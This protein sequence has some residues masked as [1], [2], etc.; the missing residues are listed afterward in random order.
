MVASFTNYFV[1]GLLQW[2]KFYKFSED[3]LYGPPVVAL[4][5]HALQF[6]YYVQP[7]EECFKLAALLSFVFSPHYSVFK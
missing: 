7:E 5:F 4:M 1:M 6:H 3:E 2:K